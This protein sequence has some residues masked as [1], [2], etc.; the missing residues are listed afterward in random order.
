[1]FFLFAVEK[2][3]ENPSNQ[4]FPLEAFH[5]GTTC[6]VY[7]LQS[8]WEA[9]FEPAWGKDVWHTRAHAHTV[10]QK[11]AHSFPLTAPFFLFIYLFFYISI[12]FCV[13]FTHTFPPQGVGGPFTGRRGA[14]DTAYDR[15]TQRQAQEIR[16]KSISCGF[17][18]RAHT[19]KHTHRI[20]VLAGSSGPARPRWENTTHQGR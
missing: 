16:R 18:V 4:H 17:R 7:L 1:M 12:S 15:T 6:G 19:H 13:A 20:Q 14:L 5:C 3:Q 11:R 2:T 10:A 9:P 8:W